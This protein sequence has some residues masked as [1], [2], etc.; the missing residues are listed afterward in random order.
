MFNGALIAVSHDQHFL[1][2]VAEEFWAV[3]K[4]KIKALDSFDSAKA[5]VYK[6][7]S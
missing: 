6:T 7:L 4:G 2:S 5:F 3:E 1:R